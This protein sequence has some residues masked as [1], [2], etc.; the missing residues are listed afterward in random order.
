MIKQIVVGSLETN[1]YIFAD[2]DT[3]DA[4][5]IDPGSNGEE[6]IRSELGNHGL[7]LKCIIN[8]HGHGDHI[9]SNRRF[10]APIYIHRLDAD[11]LENSELNL[12]ATFGLTIKSPPASRLLEEGDII[13]IGNLE[14]KVIH[15]PGHTPGS[16]CLLTNG[17]VFTGDTLFMGGVGRTDF[18]Y[19][20]EEQLINSTKQKLLILEDETVIYPGHGPMSTIG[21]EKNENY[22]ILTQN[23]SKKADQTDKI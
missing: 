10:E 13:K 21:K 19:G 3:S 15:T 14:L 23:K 5:L 8:T 6:R 12:S 18:P 7:K 4:V 16:I 22:S 20:S 17:A 11:F 9:S 1:C 2:L